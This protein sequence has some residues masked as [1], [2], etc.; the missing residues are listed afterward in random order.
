M[1]QANANHALKEDVDQ[2]LIDLYDHPSSEVALQARIKHSQIS[3]EKEDYNKALEILE[4][5]SAQDM[6]PGWDTTLEE[7]RAL[8]Y[9]Q[10][11]DF[12]SAQQVLEGLAERWPQE[13]EAQLPA[14]IGLVK[15]YQQQGRNELALATANKAQQQATDPVYQSIL[16]SLLSDIGE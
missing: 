6:G 11:Q 7:T 3:I 14:W 10:Q 16:T 9:Q 5:V 8:A 15:I 4:D 1:G 13:E 12:D 2:F